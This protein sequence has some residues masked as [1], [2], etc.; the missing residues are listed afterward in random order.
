MITDGQMKILRI[1]KRY[2]L[3]IVKQQMRLPNIYGKWGTKWIIKRIKKTQPV[4]KWHHAPCCPANHYHRT[5]I[6][7]HPCTCG[8]K[9]HNK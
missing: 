2:N 5:R 9:Y 1:L 4:D 3:I 6:V 7:L 8:A